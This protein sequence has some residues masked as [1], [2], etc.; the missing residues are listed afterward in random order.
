MSTITY[1][2]LPVAVRD[3]FKVYG[4]CCDMEAGEANPMVKQYLRS[5]TD[6]HSAF[7]RNKL[8]TGGA[9]NVMNLPHVQ[10]Q[11]LE[12]LFQKP[13]VFDELECRSTELLFKDEYNAE[14]NTTLRHTI[15]GTGSTSTPEPLDGSR[16]ARIPS[17][18][19]KTL[20]NHS[21]FHANLMKSFASYYSPVLE[22]PLHVSYQ[23]VYRWLYRLLENTPI[24]LLL[25]QRNNLLSNTT[26]NQIN[27]PFTHLKQ[28]INQLASTFKTTR[29]YHITELIDLDIFQLAIRSQNHYREALTRNEDIETI[30]FALLAA[31]EDP[32]CT[33]LAQTKNVQLLKHGH[34]CDEPLESVF[35]KFPVQNIKRDLE[36]SAIHN[37]FPY[38]LTYNDSFILTIEA[39]VVDQNHDKLIE[40]LVKFN[41]DFDISAIR[42][43]TSNNHLLQSIESSTSNSPDTYEDLIN[44]ASRTQSNVDTVIKHFAEMGL[45]NVSAN[46]TNNCIYLFNQ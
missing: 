34:L 40:T 19:N 31:I 8:V 24:V 4:Y 11:L 41:N 1:K 9:I 42:L 16:M 32:L 17:H 28:Q 45:V 44:F 12:P 18:T 38:D 43:S 13:Y 36:F 15:G 20:H 21:S 3:F 25:T 35:T 23:N 30:D 5:H 26:I 33:L 10:R 39:P 27:V 2:R 14:K 29:S 37:I 6:Q 46:P 22:V 7:I